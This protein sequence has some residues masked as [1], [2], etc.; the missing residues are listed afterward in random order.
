MKQV[1]ILTPDSNGLLQP[2]DDK[3]YLLPLVNMYGFDINNI[4][5][6][7]IST[8]KNQFNQFDYTLLSSK[9]S[10]QISKKISLLIFKSDN[11]KYL[12][13]YLDTIRFF[14][15]ILLSKIL[16]LDQINNYREADIFPSKNTYEFNYSIDNRYMAYRIGYLNQ[17][18]QWAVLRILIGAKDKIIINDLKIKLR[19]KLK[20]LS[21]YYIN[22]LKTLMPM[23]KNLVLMGPSL[24][25]L[26]SLNK[27]KINTLKEKNLLIQ[28]F[29]NSKCQIKRKKIMNIINEEL[30]SALGNTY[31]NNNS[32]LIYS[33]II[34]ELLSTSIIEDGK[35]NIIF[36][37]KYVKK[38]KFKAYLSIGSYLKEYIHSNFMTVAC[39]LNNVPVLTVQH[40]GLIGY[41]KVM[42]KFFT[43]D[44]LMA[45][46]YLS[47]GWKEYPNE[48]SECDVKAKILPLPNPYFSELKKIGLKRDFSNRKKTVLIPVSKFVTLDE[49]IGSNSSDDNI[50]ILRNFIIEFINNIEDY[51]DKIIV[52]YR[53]NNFESDPLYKFLKSKKN[54][55]N[56]LS[57]SNIKPVELFSEVDLV[58]WDV[59]STGFVE[60]LSYGL[61]TIGL[62]NKNR[63]SSNAYYYIDKLVS[64]KIL[65]YNAKSAS[66]SAV[67]MVQDHNNWI[68]Y[69][70]NI[71]VFLDKFIYTED[72]WI[73]KWEKFFYELDFTNS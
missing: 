65:H 4:K 29:K 14:V 46:F 45:D 55:I 24:K 48:Y 22:R 42:P 8:L 50:E 33:K 38:N 6:N 2:K 43:S 36:Y 72:N 7:N 51:F 18:F 9:L 28:K 15:E 58:V 61:P 12:P 35:M 40:S 66:E 26:D 67:L 73:E 19:Q 47:A 44:M 16:K 60:S 49:K 13:I 53:S 27:L 41:E 31:Y 37:E 25:R 64:N 3:D 11:E 54:K 34:S 39:K 57:N 70:R 10:V 52:I 71:S 59:T 5:S 62:L 23:K 69:F 63:W 32:L 30:I 68:K 20:I 17:N 56:I 1:I 21:F